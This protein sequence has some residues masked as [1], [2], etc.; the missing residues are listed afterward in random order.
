MSPYPKEEEEQCYAGDEVISAERPP[1]Y[2]YLPY[3]GMQFG[4]LKFFGISRHYDQITH[5]TC[6]SLL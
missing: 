3:L 2:E 4:L 1:I 6:L 5:L